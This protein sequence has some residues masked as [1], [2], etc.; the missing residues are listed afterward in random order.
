MV[1]VTLAFCSPAMELVSDL[2]IDCGIVCFQGCS[3]RNTEYIV[4]AVVFTG[5]ETKVCY[6]KLLC[7]FEFLLIPSY[8]CVVFPWFVEMFQM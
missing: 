3:L 8:T 6:Y 2:L 7:Y 4:G 5:H 1:S